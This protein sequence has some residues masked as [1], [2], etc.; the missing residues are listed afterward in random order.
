[1]ERMASGMTGDGQPR[2]PG[3]DPGAGAGA[4]DRVLAPTAPYRLVIVQNGVVLH[5]QGMRRLPITA[6]IV[7]RGWRECW[8]LCRGQLVFHVSVMKTGKK[9]D[10][11]K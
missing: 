1:M 7:P 6:T 10:T 2:G 4:A 5:D 11:R 9:A 8:L 3:V